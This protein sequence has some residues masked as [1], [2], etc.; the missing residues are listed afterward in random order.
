VWLRGAEALVRGHG[1]GAIVGDSLQ[2]PGVFLVHR[3]AIVKAFRHEYSSDVPDYVTLAACP[4][5]QRP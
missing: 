5:S 3:G 2:M 1:L 4:A